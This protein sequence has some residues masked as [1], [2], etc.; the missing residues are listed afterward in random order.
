MGKFTWTDEYSVGIKLI[1]D[2]HQHFFEIANSIIELADREGIS[3]DEL[4]FSLGELGNYALYHFSNE[5]GYFDKFEYEEAP[6][7]IAVHNQY[8]E[9]IKEYLNR[10]QTEGQGIEELAREIA[11]YSNDWLSSHILSVDK[12]YTK[13][14][15]DHGVE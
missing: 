14:L 11:S 3:K 15:K 5:E 2:Q 4:I 12:K 10:V 7:H 9:K 13:F 6:Q 8:R 1:D